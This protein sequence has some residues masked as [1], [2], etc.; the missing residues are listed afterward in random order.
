MVDLSRQSSVTKVRILV[1]G[2]L[3]LSGGWKDRPEEKGCRGGARGLPAPLSALLSLLTPLTHPP[4]TLTYH[5]TPGLYTHEQLWCLISSSCLQKSLKSPT[6]HHPPP[7]PT[8]LCK[9]NPNLHPTET[10]RPLSSRQTERGPSTAVTVVTPPVSA[11]NHCSWG[12]VLL[13]PVQEPVPVIFNTIVKQFNV[14]FQAKF[15]WKREP[16][17]NRDVRQKCRFCDGGKNGGINL[18]IVQPWFVTTWRFKQ[19]YC[20]QPNTDSIM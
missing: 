12:N 16:R 9:H 4:S 17:V 13:N 5:S 6:T 8:P 19:L 3:R 14:G 1:S 2:Q 7:P 15:R 10:S 18:A 20:L 11:C